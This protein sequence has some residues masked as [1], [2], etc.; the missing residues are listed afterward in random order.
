MT[1]QSSTSSK[2]SVLIAILSKDGECRVE[3]IPFIFKCTDL[4]GLPDHP[5]QYH[6]TVVMGCV[7]ACYAHNEAARRCLDGGYDWL[8]L[9]ADDMIP[10]EQSFLGLW[11]SQADMRMLTVYNVIGDPPRLVHMAAQMDERGYRWG[12]LHPQREPYQPA[13]CGT[14]GLAISRRILED[15]RM[16]LHEREDRF[17][18]LFQDKYD[19]WGRRPVGHDVDFVQRATDLG[20]LVEVVPEAIADHMKAVG[21]TTVA[22]MITVGW[23]KAYEG[24]LEK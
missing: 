2:Q 20:Y 13:T 16:H 3:Y 23:D 22:G 21:L 18:A 15:P 5:F 7:P 10:C 4:N 12:P 11:K 9:W 17:V 8:W 24:G 6:I 14:G 1:S 19:Q